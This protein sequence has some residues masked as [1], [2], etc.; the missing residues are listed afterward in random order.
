MNVRIFWVCAMKCMCAQTRPRF[1]LSSERVLG[2]M[3]FEPMLTPREKIPSTGKFPQR[4][5][6]PATLWT[7]SPNT[8]NELF[9]PPGAGLIWGMS[10]QGV[11]V[12]V[13]YSSVLGCLL[14]SPSS[15]YRW[16]HWFCS[17]SLKLCLHGWSSSSFHSNS[18]PRY[19]ALCT[20]SSV[21]PCK[22]YFGVMG[23]FLLV[24]DSTWHLETLNSICQ[25]FSHVSSL[26]RSSWSS[27]TSLWFSLVY[28][29][30]CHLR[31]DGQWLWCCRQDRLY[32]SGR[33]LVPGQ[34]PGVR[35]M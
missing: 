24:T 2:G 20:C 26:F 31:R 27:S 18:T 14:G 4:R 11:V 33:G 5:F 10:T 16:M 7:A 9:R 32:R 22:S 28:R 13:L 25:V 34:S 35:Q 30:S 12:R 3:E 1:I 19:L 21:C 29:E 17:P 6:K 15:F 8:T 23:F